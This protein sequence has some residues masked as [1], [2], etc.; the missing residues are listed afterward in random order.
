MNRIES[1]MVVNAACHPVRLPDGSLGQDLRSIFPGSLPH[2]PGRCERLS[3]WWL[4]S[5]WIDLVMTTSDVLVEFSSRNASLVTCQWFKSDVRW[6]LAWLG[7]AMTAGE[8]TYLL[9][10]LIGKD[11]E[12]LL[13][14]CIRDL[15]LGS[16]LAEARLTSAPAHM[17]LEW[18]WWRWSEV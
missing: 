13:Y 11:S 1:L 12:K 2:R 6:L 8:D 4:D 5:I 18:R 14:Y 17:S 9:S 16:W 7:M 15:E 10:Q 3:C